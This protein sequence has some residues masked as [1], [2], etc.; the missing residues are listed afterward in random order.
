[1]TTK[2]HDA[3]PAPAEDTKPPEKP[4]P[5]LFRFDGGPGEGFDEGVFDDAPKEEK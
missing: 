5:K 3:E 4:K 1:M 2:D